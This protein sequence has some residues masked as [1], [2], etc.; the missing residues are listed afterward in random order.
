MDNNQFANCFGFQDYDDMLSL[1]TT[2]IEDGD[3]HWN[4]T[5][6]PLEKFLVWDNTEIGDDRVEVFLDREKAEE[7]LHLLYRNSNGNQ[8]IH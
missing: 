4:I 8:G 3:S 6:L 7:Y 1:T 5:K 2:V